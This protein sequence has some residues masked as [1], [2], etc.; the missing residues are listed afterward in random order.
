IGCRRQACRL[1]AA[2]R[3]RSGTRP[4]LRWFA[5][6]SAY[7]RAL[8]RHRSATCIAWPEL[9]GT[10]LEQSAQL[11]AAVTGAGTLRCELERF[12]VVLGVDQ[13][14]AANLFLGVGEGPVDHHSFVG[15]EADL[16]GAGRGREA[17]RRRQFIG[18]RKGLGVVV[19]GAHPLL[20]GNGVDGG[21]VGFVA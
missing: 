8:P 5:P 16:L 11:D 20:L 13:K 14:E 3:C 2:P 17:A 7:P 21:E 19:I 6:A 15:V 10:G 4:S 1:C 18:P 12:S 9:L